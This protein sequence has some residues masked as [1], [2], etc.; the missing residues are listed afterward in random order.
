VVRRLIGT[1]AFVWAVAMSAG[2]ANSAILTV[3]SHGVLLGA[4]QVFVDGVR[5]SVTFEN[6]SC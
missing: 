6:G 3:S 2:A 1:V 4:K 5:Y